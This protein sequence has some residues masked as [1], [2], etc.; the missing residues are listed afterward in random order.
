MF[1]GPCH[2][3]SSKHLFSS[4]RILFI[5]QWKTKYIHISIQKVCIITSLI[6]KNI[7]IGLN[8][9][10]ITTQCPFK[11]KTDM[12]VVC[13]PAVYSVCVCVCV[14]VCVTLK[15]DFSSLGKTGKTKKQ[16]LYTHYIM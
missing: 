8:S 3:S 5:E 2:L 11:T 6:L 14:C 10:F 13:V 16:W 9:I 15:D 4:E 12:L 7:K 1:G